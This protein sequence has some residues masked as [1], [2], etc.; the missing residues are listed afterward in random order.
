MAV[1]L[2]GRLYASRLETL[3]RGTDGIVFGEQDG[4]SCGLVGSQPA[5]GT[6]SADDSSGMLENVDEKLRGIAL[7]VD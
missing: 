7:T 6:D 3:G 5:V 1:S 4:E 2:I